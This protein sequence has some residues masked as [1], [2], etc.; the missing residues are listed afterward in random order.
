[1]N[2]CLNRYTNEETAE[3]FLEARRERI[4]KEGYPTEPVLTNERNWTSEYHR[5]AE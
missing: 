4:R 5:R 1:M 3:K 2:E